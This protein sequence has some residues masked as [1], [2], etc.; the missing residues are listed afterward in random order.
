[1][2]K[3]T[4]TMNDFFCGLVLTAPEESLEKNILLLAFVRTIR[5]TVSQDTSRKGRPGK[6]ADASGGAVREHF[7]FFLSV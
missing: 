1:M 6:E 4:D 3:D 7:T 2:G 5:P